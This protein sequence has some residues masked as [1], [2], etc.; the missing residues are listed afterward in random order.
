MREVVRSTEMNKWIWRDVKGDYN[1]NL[2]FYPGT[3][4][5]G[6]KKTSNSLNQNSRSRDIDKNP[7]LA[8]HEAGAVATIS[9]LHTV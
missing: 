1:L 7:V 9:H 3:C 5:E 6:L 8:E 4:L 2:R